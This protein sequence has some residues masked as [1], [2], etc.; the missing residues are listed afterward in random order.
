MIR[1]PPRST[2]F[3]YTT[4]FRSDEIG[5]HAAR[6]DQLRDLFQMIRT[7]DE[8]HERRPREEPFLLLLRDATGHADARAALR[9]QEPIAPERGVELV[10][11]LFPDR[12]SIHQHEIRAVGRSDRPPARPR[13]GFAHALRIGLVHLA[14]ER[15][16][17]V[18]ARHGRAGIC[19]RVRLTSTVSLLTR[20]LPTRHSAAPCAPS[21]PCSSLS[22]PP[23]MPRASTATPC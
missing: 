4:L 15:V 20:N 14:A 9:L 11:G 10:L 1:R 8:I 21:P 12:A 16:N 6:V 19:H 5:L 7:K 3:P 18:A 23:R 13:Q 22:P 17:E 2:L